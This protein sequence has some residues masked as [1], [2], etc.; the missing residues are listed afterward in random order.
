MGSA[1]PPYLEIYVGSAS[2][3]HVQALGVESVAAHED[4]DVRGVILGAFR[5]GRSTLALSSGA[6]ETSQFRLALPPPLWRGNA[7]IQLRVA[8]LALGQTS[9][10]EASPLQCSPEEVTTRPTAGAGGTTARLRRGERL[11]FVR[12]LDPE[13]RARSLRPPSHDRRRQ[14]PGMSECG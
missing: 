12:L 3:R 4:G 13:A 10:V 6:P 7:H 1:L 8:E 14:H 2:Q 11:V 9:H 5:P